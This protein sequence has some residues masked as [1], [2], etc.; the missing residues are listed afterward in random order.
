MRRGL[1]PRPAAAQRAAILVLDVLTDFEFPDGARVRRALQARAQALCG[2]LARARTQVGPII[3]VNDNFG[4]WRSDAPALMTRCTSPHRAGA[5]LV[6]TLAPDADDQIV[7][8][9]RHSAF[10]GTPLAALLADRRVGTLVLTGVSVESCVWMT[11][12]DAH[13]RA[14]KLVIPADTVAGASS[15]AVRRT[16]HSLREV[17]GARVPEKASSLRFTRGHLR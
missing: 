11:A 8:K 4:E 14:F 3:Y 7:L 17:L 1:D 2:F 13:T 15:A 5:A 12:C 6:R 10:F 9:P 16:L